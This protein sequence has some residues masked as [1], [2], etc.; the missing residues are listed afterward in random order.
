MKSESFTATKT[1]S[2]DGAVWVMSFRHPMKPDPR[3][4]PGRKMRRSTGTTDEHLAQRLVDEMNRLL[5][6]A[7]WFD[8]TRQADASKVFDEIVVRAFFDDLMTPVDRSFDIR[9]ARLA[10]PGQAQ[11]YTR[12]LLVGSTGAGKTSLLRQLIGSDPKMDRFPSTSA[13]RT[14]ISDIEV[15]TAVDDLNYSCVATFF[16]EWTV[17]TLV[18]ECVADACALL[19]NEATDDRLAERLLQHRDMRFRLSYILGGWQRSAGKIE[20]EGDGFDDEIEDFDLAG[21]PT[22]T[23][24]EIDEMNGVL[25]GYVERIRVIANGAKAALA[26][27]ESDSRETRDEAQDRFEEAVQQHYDFDNLVADIMDEIRKRFDALAEGLSRRPGGWPESWTF[28]SSEREEFIPAIRR[29]SSNYAGSFGTL[30]TPLVDGIRV[31]GPFR[32]FIKTSGSKFVFIDGEGIGHSKDSA[33]GVSSHVTNRFEDVDIILLVDSA[34]A[35]MLEGPTSLIRAVAASGHHQKLVIG[36]T[37]FDALKGQANLLKATDRQAHVMASVGQALGSLRDIVGAPLVRALESDIG[38]RCFML[39]YL[40]R[41]IGEGNAAPAKA[42]QNL[43]SFLVRKGAVETL[44]LQA[45]PSYNL[46]RLHFSI[47]G[48]VNE[49]H[50]RWDAILGLGGAPGVRRAH[51]GE[52]KALN[53]RV[54]LRQENCEYRAANL[55]PVA[56]MVGRLAEKIT[57]YLN[58]PAEWN[59]PRPSEEEAMA[60]LSQIQ[61]TVYNKLKSLALRR[62]IDEPHDRWIAAF[63]LKGK[64]STFDRARAVQ[65]IL[66]EGSPTL[67]PDL[68]NIS[69]DFLE[70]IQALV[71]DAVRSSGG[72]IVSGIA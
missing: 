45:E 61:R 12:V 65:G 41:S 52:V 34:K 10:L 58:T 56:D 43:I 13:S 31:K 47:Q 37:H 50:G 71:L 54:V 26:I 69:A 16:S 57:F 1:R 66:L 39:S 25:R 72:N 55:T 4:K 28:L 32:P 64:G 35:P 44:S 62:L 63:H 42:L 59:G 15:I 14:T 46:A 9:E 51:W 20:E 36:F 40:D 21:E 11:G 3:G 38:E 8:P 24:L 30:L 33:A 23:S 5:S 18:H 68:N 53:R 22:P 67:G 19:W 6:D 49:F 60:I 17:Q 27:A 48:A 7:D 2:K 29:L 70:E